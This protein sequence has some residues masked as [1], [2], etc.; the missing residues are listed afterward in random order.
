MTGLSLTDAQVAELRD[1][2]AVNQQFGCPAGGREDIRTELAA[3]GLIVFRLRKA[4]RA[5]P[6]WFMTDAAVDYLLDL[7]KREQAA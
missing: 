5:A 4:G 1:V 7:E 3:A 2:C 6:Q